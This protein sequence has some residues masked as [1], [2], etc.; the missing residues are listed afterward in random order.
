[1]TTLI[2]KGDTVRFKTGAKPIKVTATHV[3]SSGN[4]LISGY[5]IGSGHVVNRADVSRFVRLHKHSGYNLSST[6][7]EPT[8][9]RDT[10]DINEYYCSSTCPAGWYILPG[11][12]RKIKRQDGAWFYHNEVLIPSTISAYQ[13]LK[14]GTQVYPVTDTKPPKSYDKYLSDCNWEGTRFKWG[15]GVSQYMDNDSLKDK[16]QAYLDWCADGC[17]KN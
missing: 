15:S 16:A 8:V 5:Y 3:L 10:R 2:V 13:R 11:M 4:L 1:M 9:E 17:P 12:A 7:A 6:S 14:R